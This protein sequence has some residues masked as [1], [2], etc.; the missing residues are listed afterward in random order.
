MKIAEGILYYYPRI[1]KR[2]ENITRAIGYLAEKTSFKVSGKVIAN[3]ILTLI[4]KKTKLIELKELIDGIFFNWDYD[5][6]IYFEYKYF[7]TCT[8]SQMAR[9]GIDTDSRTYF[10][11]QNKLL[12]KFFY[13]LERYG[14]DEDYLHINYGDFGF[15]NI[16][17]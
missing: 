14:I 16:K 9:I 6:K 3:R 12:K 17:E 13:D 8:K 15:E 4:W 1:D 5:D 2:I 11:K 10:R 7:K